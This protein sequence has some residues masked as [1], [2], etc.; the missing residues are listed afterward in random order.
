MKVICIGDIHASGFN[1]DPLVNNLPARLHYIKQSLEYIVN[2]GK[3]YGIN[4][5]VILGDV[6]HDKTI[7][8]NISQSVL[9]NFFVEN[10]DCKFIIISGNHDLSSTGQNQRTAIQLLNEIKNVNVIFNPTMS[11]GK[12]DNALIPDLDCFFVPYSHDF[13]GYIKDYELPDSVDVLFSH[14]G[15]NEAVLQ[16]GLSRV[17]KL[18]IKD[19]NR[20][21]LSILG[22]YHKPQ[23]LYS[24]GKTV[25]YAG[26]LIP[27]DWNDKNETK[28]FLVLD[29][30]TKDVE[31]VNLDCGVPGFYEF[32]I[33]LGTDQHTVDFILKQAESKKKLGHKVRV[34]NKN[35]IKV[36]SDISD[37]IVLEQKEIDVTNRGITVEQSKLEQCK[38][39]LEIK[40]I[41]ESEWDDYIKVL[42]DHKLLEVTGE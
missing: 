13:L 15:L 25:Y 4:T 9:H 20:F 38:K 22:H 8:Y 21:N 30:E 5:Y 1:D 11:Y 39:Y 42:Q 7:I 23:V 28:R 35:K 12:N 27:K 3:K 24:N 37:L 2:Y 34:I 36:Q 19:L 10:N 31:S 41:P 18:T 17:D 40:E 6:Y 32:V 29:T 33:P 14:I 26:S 16:S